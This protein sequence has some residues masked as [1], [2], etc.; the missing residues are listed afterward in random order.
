MEIGIGLPATIRDVE[1][2]TVVSWARHAEERGFSSLGVIDRVAYDNYEPFVSLSAAAAV[3]DRIRLVTSVLLGPLRTNHTLFAKQAASIDRLS[4]GRLVLGLGVGRR[5]D[6][7]AASG[8][9]FHRRGADLDALLE[10]ARPVWRGQAGN[11][12]PAP[13]RPGGPQVIIGGTS[14]AAYERVARHGMGWIASGGMGGDVFRSGAAA[15]R[16]AWTTAGREGEPRLMA[17]G[18]FALGDN[19]R[20][21]ADCY[22]KD[23]YAFMGAGADQVAAGALATPGQVADRIADLAEAGCEELILHPCSPDLGQVDLLADAAGL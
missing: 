9:D 16:E 22:L 12:G 21:A 23:Y 20:A 10:R 18:Y 7:Y 14:P 4:G 19:A 5:P 11:V 15:V 6:D 17:I 3:T 2:P 8:A 13:S 1:G